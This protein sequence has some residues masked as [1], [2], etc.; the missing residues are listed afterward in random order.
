MC[1]PG[2][3]AGAVL[4]EDGQELTALRPDRFVTEWSY[5]YRIDLNPIPQLLDLDG[6]GWQELWT[7]NADGTGEEQR[8]NPPEADTDAWVGSW[9]ADGRSVLF[10]S[11]RVHSQSAVNWS[12]LLPS[13]QVGRRA[14][15]NRVV[16]DRDCVIPDGMVI[17]DDP[18]ADA[19]R[20]YRTESGITLV[21]REMLRR[22]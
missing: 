10:S 14:R 1:G 21:T 6:D 8:Y 19:Q 13:V 17:G 15:L 18:A 5:P 16:V 2:P 9:S 7:M 11:V 20:F 22:L 3:V 12:V 4:H